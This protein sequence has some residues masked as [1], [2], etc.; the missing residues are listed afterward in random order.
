MECQTQCLIE[1]L[2]AISTRS[3]KPLSLLL[4]FLPQQAALCCC[5]Q[6]LAC[7]DAPLCRGLLAPYNTL[8]GANDSYCSCYPRLVQS[9]CQLPTLS[10]LLMG[11]LQ[12]PCMPLDVAHLCLRNH[13]MSCWKAAPRQACVIRRCNFC[14]ACSSKKRHSCMCVV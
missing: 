5:C 6:S 10:L 12:G 3:T 14:S 13:R 9:H 8:H 1:F 7:R 11:V 4:L 2:A